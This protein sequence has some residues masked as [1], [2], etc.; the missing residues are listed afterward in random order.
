MEAQYLH[1]LDSLLT[2]A[3][4]SKKI[5]LF[6]SHHPLVTYGFHSKSREPLRFLN[7]YTPFQLLGL[8]GVNRAMLSDIKQPR[9]RRMVNKLLAVLQKHTPYVCV[10]G[11]EHNLQH[12]VQENAAYII[13]GAGSKLKPVPEKSKSITA[14]RF[15]KSASGF[16]VLR[17]IKNMPP[18]LILFDE[19]GVEMFSAENVW[20]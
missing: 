8:L 15:S 18:K 2:L 17:F 3:E 14:L 13:S 16:A 7:N 20:R 12:I 9:Y 6:L 19:V 10:A 5:P 1:H 11:H 4:Q